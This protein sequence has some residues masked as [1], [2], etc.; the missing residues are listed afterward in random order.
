MT[1][2]AASEQMNTTIA[3]AA[4][5]MDEAANNLN[6]IASGAEEMTATISE[7]AGNTE[8]GRQIAEEAVGQTNHATTQ[9]EDLGNAA[10]Q[11]VLQHN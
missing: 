4:G 11:I 5:I 3:S 10:V 7:I 6:I 2:S 8:K 9:I 1:V